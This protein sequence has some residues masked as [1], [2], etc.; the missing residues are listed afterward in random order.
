MLRYRKYLPFFLFLILILLT[1]PF[2]SDFATSV[3]PG[4]HSTI[5]SPYFIAGSIVTITLL[6]VTVIYW[7]RA[8]RSKRIN[9]TL[10]AFHFIL[11]API[12]LFLRIPTL[13][14]PTG[15]TTFSDFERKNRGLTIFVLLI[16]SLFII[17]QLVFAFSLFK[18][19]RLKI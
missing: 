1:L 10:L 13:F 4:W 12:V 19:K 3:V 17:G 9:W 11:T 15:W 5:L 14:T 6:F 8:R 2:G 16:C 18:E 7:I